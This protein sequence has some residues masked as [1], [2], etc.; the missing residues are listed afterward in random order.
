VDRQSLQPP[1]PTTMS[2]R[3]DLRN[4]QLQL[5][6]VNDGLSLVPDDQELLDLKSELEDLISLLQD[7]LKAEQAEQDAKDRKWLEKKAAKA[8]APAQPAPP[9]LSEDNDNDNDS[10]APPEPDT[11]EKP[12]YV[13][14]KVGD[15]VSAKW[16][17]DGGY[18]PAKVTGITGSSR[19]LHYTV[20]YIK[21]DKTQVTLPGYSVKPLA[22]D[23]KRKVTAAGFDKPPPPKKVDPAAREAAEEK[24][25]RRQFEAQQAQKTQQKWQN[26]RDK[27]PKKRVG[28][29]GRAVP[30]GSTSMFHTPETPNGRGNFPVYVADVLVGVVGSGKPLTQH[31]GRVKH[32]FDKIKMLDE[33]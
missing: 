5:D 2:S 30:I 3:D 22:E 28:A 7:Q 33:D 17:G 11:H 15:V 10:P 26:F 32:K 16:S 21:W 6:Q 14:F 19:L 12:D 31:P 25:K 4:F 27:G 9:A 18:Y 23:K 20:Q 13:I 29:V 1:N 8:P 24:K